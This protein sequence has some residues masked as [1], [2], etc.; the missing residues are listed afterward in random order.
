MNNIKLLWFPSDNWGDA[1]SPHMVRFISGKNVVYSAPNKY[2]D[3]YSCIGS[4]LSHS[5]DKTIVW[6]S[7][8]IS[9]NSNII[10]QPDIRAVR[11]PLTRDLI[12]KQG[13]KCPEVYGDPALLMSH[14]YD[15][16]IDKKFKVGILPHY[17]DKESYWVVKNKTEKDVLFIDIKGGLEKVINQVK[18][19]D[20]IITS[21]LH[22]II[23]ADTYGVKSIWIKISNDIE[24]GSFK[25]NDYFL[26]I[27]QGIKQPLVVK[28]DTTIKQVLN[29]Y[30]PY[31]VNIDLEKLADACPFF[32]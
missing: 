16:D 13:Y 6:G 15:V 12:L 9:S 11:G 7:G 27:G 4:I 32:D 22:G 25:F 29:K 24:G 30:I 23:C 8:L 31:S 21:S 19:C 1:L 5:N 26:S 2:E 18:S 3:K 10:S 20:Y 28:R 14:F 17:V